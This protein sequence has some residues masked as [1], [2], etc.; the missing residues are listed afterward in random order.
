MVLTWTGSVRASMAPP[1]DEA[2]A[3]HRLWHKGLDEVLWA[4]VVHRSALIEGLTHSTATTAGLV[5]HVLPLKERV[6]EVVARDLTV[7]RTDGTTA[8]AALRTLAER[9][10]APTTPD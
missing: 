1:N 10:S 9:G 8:E 3:T 6:V 7:T 5:H 2:I 4:G